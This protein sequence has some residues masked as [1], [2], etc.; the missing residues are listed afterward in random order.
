MSPGKFPLEPLC[1]VRTVR[2]R[3]LEAVLR[4]CRERWNAAERQRIEASARWEQAVQQRQDF[5]QT[6][7]S[8]LFGSAMPTGEAMARHECHLALLDQ[9]IRQRLTE[10]EERTLECTA[11]A[12][13]L[14][15]A[16]SAWRQ[17]HS[18]LEALGEMKQE[19][20]R[21]ARSQQGLREEHSLEE[22]MQRQTTPR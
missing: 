20:Q 8:E 7:W 21:E 22:L 12:A 18:K 15:E 2:L 5:A 10:L 4:A 1:A 11:A 3:K 9:I 16:A 17:A 14:D 19:W 6:S 13:E